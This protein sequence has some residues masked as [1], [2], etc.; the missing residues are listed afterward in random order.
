MWISPRRSSSRR[1][2]RRR[3]SSTTAARRSS[4]KSRPITDAAWRIR[5]A[6]SGNRSSPTVMRLW[7]VSGIATSLTSPAIRHPPSVR[8]T[9]PRST[10]ARATSWRNSGFPSVLA[11][12]RSRIASGIPSTGTSSPISAWLSS[13]VRGR[14]S[15]SSDRCGSSVSTHCLNPQDG[16]A[17]SGRNVIRQTKGASSTSL[18]VSC[19]NASEAWSHQCRSSNTIRRGPPCANVEPTSTSVASRRKASPSKRG[20]SGSSTPS[21]ARA[22]RSLRSAHPSGASRIRPAILSRTASGG[23]ASVIEAR[24]RMIRRYYAYGCIAS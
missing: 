6:S 22:T 10:R 15:T 18:V 1:S 13:R 21:S 17:R 24:S 2:S 14:S 9:T 19:A 8:S 20:S 12:I 3:S 4:S 7:T 23:S 5:R 11:R 16:A